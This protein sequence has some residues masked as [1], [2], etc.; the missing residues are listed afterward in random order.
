M[1]EDGIYIFINESY[2]I[3]KNMQQPTKTREEFVNSYKGLLTTIVDLAE[4]FIVDLQEV[5]NRTISPERMQ[6]SYGNWIS[7][8]KKTY[9]RLSEEDIAPDDLHNWS[10]EIMGLAGWVL[11][12]ALILENKDS[13]FNGSQQWLTKHAIREY[14]ASL[15]RLKELEQEASMKEESY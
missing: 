12:L 11:D 9:L 10:E 14:Q 13:H 8:V 6:E 4:Q 5:M 2:H 1:I 3:L 15:E 7:K